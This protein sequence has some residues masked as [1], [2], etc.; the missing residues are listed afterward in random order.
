MPSEATIYRW[1]MPGGELHVP[2]FLVQYRT[3]RQWQ[4]ESL[5]ERLM[6]VAEDPSLT[7]EQRKARMD[8][9][10]AWASKL[11]AKRYGQQNISKPQE[12]RVVYED[13]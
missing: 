1:L 11:E 10:K 6:E 9:I 13:Q 8:A 3:A 2:E 4:Q 5:M 12:I 7:A